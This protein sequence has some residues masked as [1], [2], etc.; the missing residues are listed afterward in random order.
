V[1]ETYIANIET[2]ASSGVGRA[3]Q[4][5]YCCSYLTVGTSS[6]CMYG[7]SRGYFKQHLRSIY[8]WLL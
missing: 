6:Q 8:I 5:T 4:Q 2:S 1:Y 3:G 7:S